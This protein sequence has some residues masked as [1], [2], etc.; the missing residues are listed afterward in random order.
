MSLGATS[1]HLG[2]KAD[3]L[4]CFRGSGGLGPDDAGD[5]LRP[6]QRDDQVLLRGRPRLVHLRR[7][8]GAA[9]RAAQYGIW[10][11]INGTFLITGIAILLA[12]PLGP[13]VGD[14]PLASTPRRGRASRS[15]RCS[16]CWSGSR[17]SSSASSPSPSSRRRSCRAS[18]AATCR[19]S[20]PSPPR[21]DGVMIVP[22]IA[23]ISE[24]AMSAVPAGACARAPT[25]WARPSSRSRPGSSS[26][27][28]SRGS[29]PRSCSGSRGRSARR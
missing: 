29:S 4:A 17:R 1:R 8:L 22:T 9:L 12:I 20:T 3:P 24:D 15:S 10:Q 23:S 13:R 27:R 5:P 25:G 19:S 7:R 21:C 2:E 16:R 26:P 28:R 11:L 18:S 6:A 14:L